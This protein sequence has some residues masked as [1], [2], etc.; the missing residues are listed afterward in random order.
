MISNADIGTPQERL[1]SDSPQFPGVPEL[2]R[3]SSNKTGKPLTEQFEYSYVI[4]D[5]SGDAA[6]KIR[7]HQSFLFV[8][9]VKIPVAGQ[10]A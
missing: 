2:I 8:A 10:E 9:T 6:F 3:A 7:F 5:V 1:L 4:S